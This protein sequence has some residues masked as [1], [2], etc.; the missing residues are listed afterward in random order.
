MQRKNYK[1]NNNLKDN[2]FY[3]GITKEKKVS[4]NKKNN[5]NNKEKKIIKKKNNKRKMM[6]I[7]FL[8]FLI[9]CGTIYILT[10]PMFNISTINIEGSNQITVET[11][12]SLS[13]ID[14]NKTNIFSIT[15]KK[16]INNIKENP[17]VEN[18]TIQRI[19]PNTLNII[20]KERNVNYQVEKFGNYIYISSQGY[21]LET[22][23]QIMENIPIIEGLSTFNTSYKIGDRL[24]QEDLK[25][26]EII[27]KISNGF[28]YNNIEE[29]ITKIDVSNTLEY[30]IELEKE[31]KTVYLGDASSLN[32]RILWLKKI[33]EK[34]KGIKGEIF[35]NGDLSTDRIFFREE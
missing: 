33:L 29:E 14:L 23:N 21:I 10:T 16:I 34:A 7:L 20:A 8:L 31:G 24:N 27:L 17:Y 4:N 2:E 18:V 11:Y 26:M 32:E 5:K 6:S 15:N 25:K 13:Q 19:Y 3:I 9:F 12:I 30:I 22:K 35:I 28:K 1:R